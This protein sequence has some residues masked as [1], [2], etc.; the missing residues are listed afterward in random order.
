M[1]NFPDTPVTSPTASTAVFNG[2]TYTW[3]G[4]AWVGTTSSSSSGGGTSG[5]S[6]ITAGPNIEVNSSTGAVT[7]SATDL[8][9]TFNVRQYMIKN[10]ASADTAITA[11]FAWAMS[12]LSGA[13]PCIFFPAGVYQCSAKNL[14]ANG[15]VNSKTQI[16]IKGAG[17]GDSTEIQLSGSWTINHPVNI[18]GIF[19]NQND[20]TSFSSLSF[21]RSD[22]GGDA[23]EDDMDTSISDCVF[24]SA[25]GTNSIDVDYRGRNLELYNCRFKTGGTAGRAIKLSYYN[26]SAENVVQSSLGWKRILIHDNVFHN[27]PKCVDIHAP[28]NFSSGEPRLR[29][30]IFSGN[31][32]ET[33]GTF[34]DANRTNVILEAASIMNNTCQVNQNGTALIAF[35]FEKFYYSTFIGNTVFGN[36]GQ[37]RYARLLNA[38][39]AKG[40]V[41]NGNIV[42][43]CDSSGGITGTMNGC[44]IS[45]NIGTA[46]SGS[47]I[48]NVSGTNS[49]ASN[50]DLTYSST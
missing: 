12:N 24:N 17:R 4:H 10:N 22:T 7:V 23:R 49:L 45:G 26:N 18:Q 38:D 39:D 19:F 43:M 13:A 40:C 42:H 16:T 37:T 15:S 14:S 25:G 28:T 27:Y 29:G 31:A 50:Q 30:F 36:V 47:N 3:N 9:D 21:R 41:I 11:A 35:D 20:D 1:P 34:I 8:P 46:P 33:S 44:R 48:V 2:V 32:Q 5:V 6:S